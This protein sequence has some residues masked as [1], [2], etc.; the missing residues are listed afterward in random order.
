MGTELIGAEV[1]AHVEVDALVGGEVHVFVVLGRAVVPR[2]D[3]ED[4]TIGQ[5]LVLAHDAGS[6]AAEEGWE[7]LLFC[8]E[9][10]AAKTTTIGRRCIELEGLLAK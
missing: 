6:A 8:S 3:P 10:L 1:V 4:A 5:V 7:E 9:A 2:E